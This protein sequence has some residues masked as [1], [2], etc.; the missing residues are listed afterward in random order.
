MAD[1]TAPKQR[2][3]PF[4]KGKSG[5]AQGRPRGSRNR[6]TLLAQGLLDGQA[7]A[8]VQALVQK[9]LAGD[10]AALRVAIERLVPPCRDRALAPNGLR[11]PKLRP[12]NLAEASAVILRAVVR[13][14]LTP[15]EGASLA[16]LLETHRR[17][18]EQC[19]LERQVEELRN[20]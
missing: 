17:C 14:K 1:N 12:E 2:G 10:V 4:P 20:S 9:A 7:E 3:K 5:N 11:L 13:G 19:E 8:L 15:V 16:G 6:A 18:V